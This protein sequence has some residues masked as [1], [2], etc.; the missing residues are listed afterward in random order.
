MQIAP[1]KFIKKFREEGT[2][3][4][5]S[6]IL[7]DEDPSGECYVITLE[8]M[9]G[10]ALS[11]DPHAMVAL[12]KYFI[13][14]YDTEIVYNYYVYS[15]KHKTIQRYEITKHGVHPIS[16]HVTEAQ[17]AAAVGCKSASMALKQFHCAG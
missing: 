4:Y 16:V 7:I 8:D 1:F 17:S 10:H 5:F 14:E 13:S 3:R 2:E 9:I 15:M 6:N 11:G 12:K